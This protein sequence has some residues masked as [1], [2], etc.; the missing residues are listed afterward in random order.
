VV[1]LAAFS[2]GLALY[3]WAPAT[4]RRL[5]LSALDTRFAVRGAQA[6]EASIALVG[7]DPAAGRADHA[8]MIDRLVD[9]GARTI[10]YDIVFDLPTQS[11]ADDEALAAAIERAG[12][13]LV[14]A[15][16]GGEIVARELGAPVRTN[17]G[18]RLG[19][20]TTDVQDAPILNQPGLIARAGAVG[21]FAGFPDDPGRRLRRVAYE[22]PLGSN[23]GYPTFAW[24]AAKLAR[25][26]LAL[27]TLPDGSRRALGT[28]NAR[29]AWID[30]AGGSGRYRPLTVQRVLDRPEALRGKVVVVGYT[31]DPDDRH[32]TS[33][34]SER[35]MAGVEVQANAI[36]T[37]L[38]EAPLRDAPIIVD[39]LVLLAAAAAPVVIWRAR[40]PWRL[41]GLAALG[42]A[43]LVAFQLAFNSGVVLAVVPPVVALLA[44]TLALL[45]RDLALRRH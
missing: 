39:L 7:I 30:F 23:L 6:P 16:N 27:D 2:L 21:A 20:E 40:W 45:G 37:L 5:E 41:A 44:S 19:N 24:C 8:A 25:P 43:L 32:R 13:R 33:M 11:R 17:C 34:S 14:L 26:D 3:V 29:H 4:A 12:P 35:P 28:V 9:A 22:F 42:V 18:V 1:T 36:A 31:D 15:T 10:A 38:R